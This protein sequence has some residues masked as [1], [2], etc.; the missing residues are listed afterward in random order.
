MQFAS[1]SEEPEQASPTISAALIDSLFEAPR[2][3]LAGLVFVSIGAALTALKTAE[4]LIWACVGFLALAGIIRAFD[5]QLYQRRKSTLTTE[6]AARWQKRYQIGAMIQAA[7]IGTWCST[8]LLASDDAVAHMIA[9]SVT[10]GIAAGGAGR[11]YGRQWIFQL[12]VSLVF[13]PIVIAL[14]LRGTPFYVAMSVVSAAFLLSLMGISANLH[15]IFMRALIAR[16]REA[17]LA[18]QFDT[19]LNNMPHG[20]C[21]FH[22]DGQLAVVNHRFGE[23]T[24]LPNDCVQN[25][26]SAPEIIA[27]CIDAGSI[28]R[29]NGNLILHGIRELRNRDRD[30]RYRPCTWSYAV[31]DDSADD[32][33]RCCRPAGG[34][35]RAQ[36]CRGKDQPSGPL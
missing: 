11:A 4:P 20:L 31:V 8:T 34:H 18:G 32:G 14:A 23:M 28:S 5:L 1:Q 10:T 6:E 36:E 2:P 29:E 25:G 16:E 3:L 12:Q 26:A 17:A 33:R 7:A 19:A 15:R 9:L 22:G 35:Y 30:A 27:A 13:V 24:N 21:M